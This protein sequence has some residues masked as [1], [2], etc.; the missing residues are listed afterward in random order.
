MRVL[1]HDSYTHRGRLTMP[2]TRR[3]GVL[4]FVFLFVSI[5]LLVLSRLNHQLITTT[6][7]EVLRIVAPAYELASVPVLRLR[8]AARQLSDY[9]V[10]YE[11]LDRLKRENQAL[12]QW[13]W[14]AR[15]LQRQVSDYQKLVK[16]VPESDLAFATGRVIAD[17]R[18]PFVRSALLNVGRANGVRNGYAVVNGDGLVGRTV[19]TADDVTRILLLN[20]FN[21]RIPVSVGDDAH[22]GMLVGDNGVRPSI[23]FLKQKD[24][25][26]VG[27]L[28]FTS[29]HGGLFPRGLRIGRVAEISEPG[30]GRLRVKLF[31]KLDEL[32][33]LSVLFHT[34]PTID[35]ADRNDV[36]RGQRQLERLKKRTEKV[37]ARAALPGSNAK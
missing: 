35:I 17:A 15:Q 8:R 6:R 25:V 31:A 30:S 7:G 20:D 37:K 16:A 24:Q 9:F 2:I 23:S 1:R 28:V 29:G 33:F 4:I 22:R 11:K 26:K 12:R 36:K 14:R 10:F 18:G 5:S 27:D 32:D 3:G 21:S 34:T 19:D 13:K